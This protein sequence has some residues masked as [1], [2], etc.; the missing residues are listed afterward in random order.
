LRP[1]LVCEIDWDADA[2]L[3]EGLEVV[4]QTEALPALVAAAIA[5]DAWRRIA[6]LQRG[7]WLGSLLMSGLLKA[8]GKTRHHLVARE[9]GV[10][11]APYRRIHFH[12]LAQRIAGFL[13]GV[14]A[15][16]ERGHK[17]LDRLS[18]ARE[19][20]SLKL[21]GRRSTSRLPDLIELVLSKPLISV[22]FAAKELKVSAQ[23]VEGMLKELGTVRELTGRGRY[24]AWGIV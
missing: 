5:H 21:K 10:R 3:S 15:A 11:S 23:A 2:R 19:M 20:M 18:L 7:G 12:D 6:P 16:A 22:P 9:T 4:K 1:E 8:R 14:A 13:E 17:D 24:R